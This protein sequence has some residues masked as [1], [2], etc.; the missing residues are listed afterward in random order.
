MSRGELRVVV[1]DAAGNEVERHVAACPGE[2]RVAQ[3]LWL[4]LGGRHA[5]V[6][7]LRLNGATGGEREMRAI[8]V[9]LRCP[10][11][12]ERPFASCGI[13]ALHT[14]EEGDFVVCGGCFRRVEM[15]R[16]PSSPPGG[17]TRLRVGSG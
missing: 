11:C 14:D 2:L 5:L 16:I 1:E 15:Q 6:R 8:E 10:F 7:V 9:Q 3:E 17:P 4:L 13:A 12:G